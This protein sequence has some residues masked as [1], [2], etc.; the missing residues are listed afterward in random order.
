MPDPTPAWRPTR[1]LAEATAFALE[2]HGGDARKATAIPYV[3]HLFSVCGMVIADGGSE[4]EAAAALLH[5]ALEDHPERA[6][7]AAL[8]GRFGER[9][10]EIVAGCSDTPVDYAGGAKP[11][12]RER[13]AAYLAH[14]ATVNRGTL[15]VALAD[16][17]DNARAMLADHL[18]IG[19]ALWSR[20]NAGKEDQLWYLASLL[21]AFA[22]RGVEGRLMTEFGQTVRAL[23]SA[24][25]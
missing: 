9:V 3:S 18:Q 5:D 12:W 11:P 7:R 21:E 1:L 25:R 23:L 16:K 24:C 8:A 14:L 2:L 20:F 22:A 15:R 6:N 19:D 10:A 17:L 13:K 4:E